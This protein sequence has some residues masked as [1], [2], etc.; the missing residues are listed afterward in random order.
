VLTRLL[1]HINTSRSACSCILC[2]TAI[3]TK[4]HQNICLCT[5]CLRDLPTIIN[6]RTINCSRCGNALQTVSVAKGMIKNGATCGRCQTN[7]IFVDSTFSL[8]HYKM[9]I[10][11]FIKQIKFHN[12]LV[13]ADLLGKLM[14]HHIIQ[15]K[16]QKPDAIIP[17][18]LH[19]K[20]LRQR[21]YNQALE[22]AKPLSKHLNI[23]ILSNH[24]VR[25]KH[26]RPQTD[27]SIKE[28][29]RNISN[30]FTVTNLPQ[31]KNIAIVDDVITTG[32]TIN[33]AA[34][35]LKQN[36]VEQVFAWSCANTNLVK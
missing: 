1:S 17:I 22:I 25:N 27:C 10:D 4:I 12:S 3:T 19:F 34:K 9:P 35:V 36:G 21:G 18:P 2:H 31:Y 28:R 8:F 26:T 16:L 30:S 23:P 13:I 32:A 6:S 20:R 7:T 14:A 29:K 11:Y 15:H 33:E 5:D 24:L